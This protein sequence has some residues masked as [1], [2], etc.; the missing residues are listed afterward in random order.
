MKKVKNTISFKSTLPF[1]LVVSAL[2]NCWFIYT[3]YII[4]EKEISI[5]VLEIYPI[6]QILSN[7]REPNFTDIATPNKSP[8]GGPDFEY[9]R[10]TADYL[11]PSYAI[12]FGT[13]HYGIDI[14]PTDEYFKSKPF[15]LSRTRA[16]VFSTIS[17]NVEYYLDEFGANYLIIT[18]PQKTIRTFYVH[19]EASYVDT[20]DVVVAG[21]PIGVMGATGKATGSHLH[22]AIQ[23]KNA[24]GYWQFA[25]PKK[26]IL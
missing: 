15:F 23:T 3:A 6:P 13:Q 4:G 1:L 12:Q 14:V 5:D 19:L 2:L 10:L 8:F 25:D 17:G 22:Y 18:N 7:Y 21:Q 11:S 26:Y 16:L 20:G 9:T 24:R